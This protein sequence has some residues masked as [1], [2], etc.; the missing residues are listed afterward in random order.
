MIHELPIEKLRTQTPGCQQV[1]HLN[2]AG[3]ALMPLNVINAM[4]EHLDLEANIGGYEAAVVNSNKVEKMYHSAAQLIHSQPEEI[5]F[6]ENATRAWEMIFYSFKFNPG[7]RVVTT[8]AEYASNYLAF[9]N[10]AKNRQIIIDVIENDVTGQLDINAF[11]DHVKKNQNIKLVAITHV[12]TQ[13]GLINP[14]AQVGK[15]TQEMQIPYLLDA[16][17]SVGQMPIDVNEMGCDFLCATGRKYLRGP[18]GTGFLYINKTKIT[19]YE[20]P[21]ID[22]HSA[23]WCSDNQYVL[24]QDARRF[25]TWEQNIAAKVGLGV[26]IDYALECKIDAIWN[27]IQHLATQLRTQLQTNAEVTLQ[28]RG[29]HQCGIITFTSK[30]KSPHAIQAALAKQRINVSISLAEYARLD[31]ANRNLPA[32]VRA[33]VHYYNTEEEIHRFCDALKAI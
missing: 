24:R 2:N 7:D 10:V 28:D 32:V 33:S 23:T 19:Q 15:I 3:A 14:A 6:M 29:E 13:G 11:N 12:P 9:L 18:R 5:A 26:A 17:Q 30:N 22:L 21:F 4:K 16:T 20:P 27:R 1:L 8:R 25:E 31:L